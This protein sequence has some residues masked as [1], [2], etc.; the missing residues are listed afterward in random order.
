MDH[1]FGYRNLSSLAGG[2]CL[3]GMIHSKEPN[4]SLQRNA[5]NRLFCG[6]ALSSA[7][8]I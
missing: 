6:S 1:I 8:L 2:E 5:G 7:W 3:D 4:Q